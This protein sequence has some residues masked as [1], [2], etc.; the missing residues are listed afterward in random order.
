MKTS[1]KII[2]RIYN[3][4]GIFFIARYW[5]INEC[6]FEVSIKNVIL[7]IL[8]FSFLISVISSAW[9]RFK[10]DEENNKNDVINDI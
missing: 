3:L 6:A 7:T 9:I 2:I 5:Y 1:D 8:F 4:I 10:K